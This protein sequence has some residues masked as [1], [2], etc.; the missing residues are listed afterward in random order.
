MDI[1]LFLFILYYLLYRAILVH[2]SWLF[3]GLL[4]VAY[5]IFVAYTAKHHGELASDTF[6]RS[7]VI[8][9]LR[10]YFD[11]GIYKEQRLIPSGPMIYASYPHGFLPLSLLLGYGLH[12]NLPR[13]ADRVVISP[14]FFK[15]PIIRELCLFGG[16]IAAGKRELARQLHR[17]RSVILAPEGAL[18]VRAARNYSLNIDALEIGRAPGEH[19]ILQ[20][21]WDLN[22]PVTPVFNIGEQHVF[23]VGHYLFRD[24]REYM[25]RRF[26][27]CFPLLGI[28]PFPAKISSIIGVPINP[29]LD[30]NDTLDKFHRRFAVALAKIIREHTGSD[31]VS[32]KLGEWVVGTLELADS[33]SE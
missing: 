9:W 16:A 5:V 4:A 25:I 29:R 18:G 12:G 30:D 8:D 28:G 6:R 10:R 15:F 23:W 32:T 17:N 7:G 19:D 13:V 24:L 31:E 14:H 26:S 27:Y 22:V 2:F 33:P 20:V 21:A 1:T 11:F 3:I